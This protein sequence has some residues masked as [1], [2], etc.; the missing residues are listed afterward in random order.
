VIANPAAPKLDE[1]KHGF[2]TVSA[3]RFSRLQLRTTL[4]TE[5]RFSSRAAQI[6][7]CA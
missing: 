6:L 5:H 2:A 1:P 7:P 3:A 4:I